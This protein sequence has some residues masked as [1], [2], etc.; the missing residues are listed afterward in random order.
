MVLRADPRHL[1]VSSV[2]NSV[3]RDAALLAE[4]VRGPGRFAR[5]DQLVRATLSIVSNIAE[6][7]GR[8]TVPEF[9]RFLLIARGSAQETLA[10]LRLVDATDAAQTSRLQSLRSRTVLILKM[11]SRLYAHPPPDK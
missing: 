3:A 1:L 2:A 8:G 6:G 4:T 9:R 5:G 11:I 7:C 10:Q